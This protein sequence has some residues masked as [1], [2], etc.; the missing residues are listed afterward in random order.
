MPREQIGRGQPRVVHLPDGPR[1]F[2]EDT[3]AQPGVVAMLKKILHGLLAGG[4]FSED[5]R[6]LFPERPAFFTVGHQ[7]G[8]VQSGALQGQ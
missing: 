6:K 4:G 1:Q 3:A 5:E 8:G 7:R 2:V